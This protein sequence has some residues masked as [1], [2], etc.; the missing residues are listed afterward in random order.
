VAHVWHGPWTVLINIFMSFNFAVIFNFNVL[1]LR[2]RKVKHNFL[3]EEDGDKQG[4][5]KIGRRR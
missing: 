1:A 5:V 4:D 3:G 2:F